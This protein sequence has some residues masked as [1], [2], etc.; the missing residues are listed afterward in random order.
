MKQMQIIEKSSFLF[1][2]K[3]TSWFSALDKTPNWKKLY[4]VHLMQS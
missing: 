3:W 1:N 2:D 4:L